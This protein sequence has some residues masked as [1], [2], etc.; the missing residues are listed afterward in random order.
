MECR[1]GIRIPSGGSP[2][3]SAQTGF[4]FYA[5]FAAMTNRHR[6]QGLPQRPVSKR[7]CLTDGFAG[8]Y[9]VATF[10]HNRRPKRTKASMRMSIQ[11]RSSQRR[12]R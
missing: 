11:S 10:V 3:S 7:G 1:I 4:C 2:A 8:F 6:R 9:K 12:N 5:I